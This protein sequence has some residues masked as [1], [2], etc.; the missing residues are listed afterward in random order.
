[1]SCQYETW[2]VSFSVADHGI[3]LVAVSTSQVNPGAKFIMLPFK[4]GTNATISGFYTSDCCTPRVTIAASD[5]LGNTGYCKVD[6]ISGDT[7]EANNEETSR[8]FLILLIAFI[9]SI[10][11]ALIV[12]VALVA[13]IATRRS[14]KRSQ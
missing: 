8:D 5:L 6:Y 3:G 7:K 10:L 4:I 9:I 1:M 11:L 12:I 13:V 14:K 2:H